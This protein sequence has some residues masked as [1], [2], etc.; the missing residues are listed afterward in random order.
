MY[1]HALTNLN[2]VLLN[3]VAF[4]L[5]GL[6]QLVVAHRRQTRPHWS[7]SLIVVAFRF[8]G[9]RRVLSAASHFVDGTD[10]TTQPP[11]PSCVCITWYDRY[12]Q[13]V[14]MVRCAHLCPCPSLCPSARCSMRFNVAPGFAWLFRLLRAVEPSSPHRNTSYP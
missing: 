9:P 13:S 7:S 4:V 14:Q 5:V 8:Y 6:P 10:S 3:S 11:S 2:I 12:E 1:W